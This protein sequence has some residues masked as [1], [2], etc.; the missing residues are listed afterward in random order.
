MA[1]KKIFKMLLIITLISFII[2]SSTYGIY[3]HSTSY[4]TDLEFDFT[5][6][7]SSTNSATFFLLL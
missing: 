7:L 5:S 2:P 3:K 6:I 4:T 1:L